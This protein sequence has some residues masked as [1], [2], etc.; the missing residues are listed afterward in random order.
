MKGG[1]DGVR[2]VGREGI[3]VWRLVASNLSCDVS[4]ELDKKDGKDTMSALN[5]R[6]EPIKK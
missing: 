5:L 2:K 6:Q 1:N 4:I 3:F